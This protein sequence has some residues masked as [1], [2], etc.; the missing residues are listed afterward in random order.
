MSFHIIGDAD[1]V[2]GYRFAGVPTTVVEGT[3]AAHE[4]F[5]R[6]L[7]EGRCRILLLTEAVEA[8]L[9]DVLTAHRLAAD[10]PYVVVVEDLW[11]PRGGRKTLE[12]LI[13]EAVGIRIVK[14]EDTDE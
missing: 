4:A 11:G 7:A 5:R 1:T 12:D 6:V 9:G 2:L 8:M 14:D 13:Y 3:P 10:P